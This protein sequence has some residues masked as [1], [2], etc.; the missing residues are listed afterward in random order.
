MHQLL[1]NK[2]HTVMSQTNSIYTQVH[3]T[4]SRRTKWQIYTGARHKVVHEEQND[5]YIPLLLP[6]MTD[7]SL[8]DESRSAFVEENTTSTDGKRSKHSTRETGR[9]VNRMSDGWIR[10]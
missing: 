6:V 7:V 2:R 1:R 9:H 8:A 4:T 10:M 5:K 3:D